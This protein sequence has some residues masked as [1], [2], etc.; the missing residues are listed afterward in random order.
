MKPEILAIEGGRYVCVLKCH[1]ELL[2]DYLLGGGVACAPAELPVH[3]YYGLVRLIR[4][5]SLRR[6]K[7]LLNLWVPPGQP[8]S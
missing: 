1:A 4:A 8:A 6:A 5:A 3:C 2:R 7:A